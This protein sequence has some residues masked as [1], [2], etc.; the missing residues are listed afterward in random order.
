M[1]HRLCNLVLF[2][3]VSAVY[4]PHILVWQTKK[5]DWCIPSFSLSLDDLHIYKKNA[6]KIQDKKYTCTMNSWTLHEIISLWITVYISECLHR[7]AEGIKGIWRNCITTARS[8]SSKS[9]SSLTFMILLQPFCLAWLTFHCLFRRSK[10]QWRASQKRENLWSEKG[11][12]SLRR[13]PKWREL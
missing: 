5:V 3:S 6:S 7:S 1:A 10:Q 8:A 4:Q 11:K 13:L 2:G 12:T 9:S